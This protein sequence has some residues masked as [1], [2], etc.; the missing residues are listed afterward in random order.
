MQNEKK[1]YMN[2]EDMLRILELRL[3]PYIQLAFKLVDIRRINHGNMFRHQ[4][5]TLFVLFDYGFTDHILLKASV[6]HDLL[7]DT[8]TNTEEIERLEEGAEVLKLVLEV[9]RKKD[10]TKNAF[11]ERIMKYGSDRAKILKCADRI[12][13]LTDIGFA[14]ERSKLLKTIEETETF[15]LPMATQVCPFMVIELED[16]LASRKQIA[17]KI[18]SF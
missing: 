6:I 1:H 17:E 18:K 5:H 13:N 3:A 7:E 8:D 16:L 11:L 4:G 15:I 10:E 14:S 12:A 9:T 2:D